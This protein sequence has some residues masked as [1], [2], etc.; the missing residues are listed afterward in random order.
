MMR[1][2]N[3]YPLSKGI[4]RILLSWFILVT[5]LL[6]TV[7]PVFAS[8][9]L[10]QSSLD[11]SVIKN[12]SAQETTSSDTSL[13]TSNDSS[14]VSTDE[15]ITEES[16]TPKSTA[17]T[18]IKEIPEVTPSDVSIE[19][20][21][22]PEQ[23]LISE[24]EV[25]ASTIGS[26]S[27]SSA[28]KE[29]TQTVQEVTVSLTSS[30]DTNDVTSVGSIDMITSQTYT[31]VTAQI[32][33]TGQKPQHIPSLELQDENECVESYVTIDFL[34][35]SI[36][37][38]GEEIQSMTMTLKIKKNLNSHITSTENQIYVLNSNANT[39]VSLA[40]PFI[41]EIVTPY[42]SGV[43]EQ[44]IPTEITEDDEYIY[45]QVETSSYFAAYAVVEAGIIEIQPYQSRMPQIPW[46]AIVLTIIVA[47]ALLLIV[48]FKTGFIYR[49][50]NHAD[51]KNKEK[52]LKETNQKWSYKIKLA[53]T[54]PAL[55][56][57]RSPILYYPT[58]PY[59][60]QII[61]ASTH[62]QETCEKQE[63]DPM[64]L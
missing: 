32:T 36:I 1:E 55:Q 53:T 7:I 47:T 43:W 44:V 5:L 22:T 52:F 46:S 62:I 41:Q 17:E 34:A 28:E 9:T 63:E 8:L 15:L 56:T 20:I 49:V 29:S 58:V 59:P 27:T 14:V 10:K 6:L 3:P 50:D 45:Y 2:K 31:D 57:I 16:Q 4:R 64:Y 24:T 11:Q 42:K 33:I 61:T 35:D 18:V 39:L 25:S 51:G 30:L 48:I 37:L 12:V 38:S 54:P 13:D 60:S 21:S 23:T 26:Q 19:M 40:Q